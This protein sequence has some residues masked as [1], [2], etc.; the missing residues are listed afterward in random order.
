MIHLSSWQEEKIQRVS[1]KALDHIQSIPQDT[2]GLDISVVG[3]A[4]RDAL[5]KGETENDL[6]FVVTNET[7]DGMYGRDFIDIDASSFGVLHDGAHE[8]WGLARTET[9]PD[10]A[11][12]Y[13]GIEVDTGASLY[14]DLHRRDTRMNAIA[15]LVQGNPSVKGKIKDKDIRQ[16]SLNDGRNTVY[17]I[18]P[19]DGVADINNGIIRHVSEAFVEDPIRVLRVARQSASNETTNQSADADTTSSE[20]EPFAVHPDTKEMLTRVA[21]ELNRMSR[22]RI[23]EEIE[24]AMKRAK[25]PT[26]FWEVLHDVGGLAVI[27]PRLDRSSII[28]A[29]PE[30][31]HRE[32]DAFTHAMMVLDQMHT[33]CEDRDIT[34]V[35]RVRRYMMAVSHDLGKTT[36]ANRQGGIWSDDPPRRFPGHDEVGKE[37]AADMAHRLGLDKHYKRVMEAGALLHMDFHDLPRWEPQRVIEFVDKHDQPP[38]AKTPYTA[39]IEELLDLVHADHQGRFQNE[40]VFDAEDEYMEDQEAPDGSR[41]PDFNRDPFEAII[42]RTRE[43][44]ERIDGYSVLRTGLCDKHSDNDIEDEALASHLSACEACASPG[45]WVGERLNELRINMIDERSQNLALQ[46]GEDANA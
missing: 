45:E 26:R 7:V 16:I 33:L 13:K 3:G 24:K 25:D 38:E 35:D 21:Y 17:L 20:V 42:N 10:D 27:T 30:K 28:Y 18:D 2:D 46:R 6:D 39:T 22:E 9:K 31:Y 34:G 40:S 44:I 1:E 29:G 32:G 11:D 12:G 43:S 8:E 41:R 19:F 36:L 14:D 4:C 23:G 15:I 5:I 37:N